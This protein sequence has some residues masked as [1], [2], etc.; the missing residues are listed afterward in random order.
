MKVTDLDTPALLIDKEI[1]LS[2]MQKMQ[3]YADR[4]HVSLRP[5]AK[6]HKSSY[7]ASLQIAFGAKG[8]AVAKI[9]EA[10]VMAES[11]LRDILI[12]N[13]IVGEIKLKRIAQ[14]AG[15]AHVMFGA[16]SVFQIEQAE[17]VFSEAGQTAEILIEVEVGE[18]RSGVDKEEELNPL[19][20]TLKRCAHVRLRGVFGHDGNT[21]NTES[22]ESCARI[23]LAAQA[24]LV[25]FSNL[26]RSCGF[27]T[28]IVS[29]GST[30]PL[31][32]EVP[33]VEGITEIRP[34]TYALMDVSQGNAQGTL[35]MC[36][37]SV[38]A[39]IISKTKPDRVVLDVGAKG[40]T[41]QERTV[42]IC[43]S[44][45]KGV[46]LGCTGTTIGRMFDEHAIINSGDFYDS[47][48]LGQKVRVIPVHICPVCNLYEK[49]Y[50]ISG[51]EVV[52]EIC[53]DTR[54]KLQ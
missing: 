26:I 44:H 20:E 51:E 24:K 35:S 12:A 13:E 23:S 28:D 19:L 21:Y 38:L 46:I 11:G 42:G 3:R 18:Q 49:A 40:L 15:K 30:P 16:D 2:N 31:V 47:V 41:M 53:M 22:L 5:H 14:L 50:L 25:R 27:P 10:E 45:G 37:A 33:I 9:G 48:S 17:R 4:S 43:N 29:Y 7:L 6:T 34:G 32:Y 36:A 8:I 54:G 39:S 52:R 1:L